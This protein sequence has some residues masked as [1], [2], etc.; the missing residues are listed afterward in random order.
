VAV[1]DV[2]GIP[3]HRLCIS[4]CAPA[5]QFR[6]IPKLVFEAAIM[7]RPLEIV[8]VGAADRGLAAG[9]KSCRAGARTQVPA[10][11]RLEATSTKRMRGRCG[12]NASRWR[13]R[14]V[15]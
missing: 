13:R 3:P 7:Q 14:D 1:T 8:T 15:R 6:T 11:L 2:G 12:C 10:A 9:D 4:G 5:V